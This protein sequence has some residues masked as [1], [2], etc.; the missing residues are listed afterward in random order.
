MPDVTVL[1]V[2]IGY[3]GLWRMPTSEL[4]FYGSYSANVP[5]L[6]DGGGNTFQAVRTDATPTYHILRW[7]ASYSRVL[8]YEWQFRAV[9]NGQYTNDALIPGEQ[10]GYGGPDSVRGF[11]VR[12]VANDRGWSSSVELYTPDLGTY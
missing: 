8:P 1:P 3:N 4:G 2:S 10:F 7:G 11:N 12:E 9:A 5:G 6:N